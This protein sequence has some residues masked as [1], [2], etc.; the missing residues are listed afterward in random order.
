MSFKFNNNRFGEDNASEDRH[1][2]KFGGIGGGTSHHR[3]GVNK[4]GKIEATRSML[5]TQMKNKLDIYNILSKEGQYY[6]PPLTDCA[7]G[8]IKD[9]LTGMKKVSRIH[10]LHVS[11]LIQF[12]RKL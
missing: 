10:L 11:F 5:G 6:L 4:N 12:Y 9:I 7:M 2:S 3:G 8:F 1:Y